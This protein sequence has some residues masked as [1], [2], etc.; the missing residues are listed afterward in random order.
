MPPV[1]DM[2]R[3]VKDIGKGKALVDVVG[4]V[5]PSET[6]PK[7]KKARVEIPCEESPSL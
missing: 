5:S 4:V 6:T 2:L 3:M 1:H 7:D